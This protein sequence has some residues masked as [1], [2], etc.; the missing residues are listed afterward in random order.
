MALA[1]LN[2]DFT[3][4]EKVA[5]LE[6]ENAQMR[7]VLCAV[8]KELSAFGLDMA[9][10]AGAMQEISES[11]IEEVKQFDVLTSDLKAVKASTSE[12]NMSMQHA[13]DVT[14]QVGNELGQ[15][16]QSANEALIAIQ[17]LIA[18]VSGF[19]NNMDELNG[20]MESVRSVTGL[21]ETI[22]RQTNLL[23]LN[24][25]IEAARA[26]EAGKGFAVV[27][28]EVKQLAQNT[29]SATTEIEATITRVRSG[30]TQLN[31]QSGGATEK[32]VAVNESAGSFAEILT[33]VGSAIAQIDQSTSDVSG[34]ANQVDD[35]CSVF[36]DAFGQLSTVS[37]NSSQELVHFSSQL[38]SIADKLDHLTADVLQIGAETEET[39]FLNIA[40]DHAQ[41]VSQV[42]ESAVENGDISQ[43]DLFNVD[44][45][46][47]PGTNPPRYKTPS[48]PLI[49]QRIAH[50]NDAIADTRDEIVFLIIADREGYVPVHVKKF[51]KPMSDDPV[52]NTANCRNRNLFRDRIGLKAA[53]NQKEILLQSYRRDMGG[54]VFVLMKE[55]NAPI[56]VKGRHWGNIRLAYKQD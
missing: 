5:Q 17:E 2:P 48:L 13:R 40:R 23:A 43:D 1:A 47:I 38:Q 30:L 27:A 36:S 14:Q 28:S 41:T 12:I 54:G 7:D 4:E 50:L 20:A 31:D 25:T 29:T 35:T 56:I 11:S 53:Q 45:E 22:A 9:A 8:S 33:L 3:I 51:S 37:S 34:H 16:Q 44:H 52:W 6:T 42:L 19:D 46:E 39:V 49:E 32:A 18:D 24:A 21:I 55:L 10:I 26:G 15:S